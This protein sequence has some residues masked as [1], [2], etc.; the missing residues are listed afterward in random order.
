MVVIF[1]GDIGDNIHYYEMGM[2]AP[3]HIFLWWICIYTSALCGE[4][5]IVVVFQVG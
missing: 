2:S 1:S 3:A 5:G 4:W